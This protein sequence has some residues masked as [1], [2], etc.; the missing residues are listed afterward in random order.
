MNTVWYYSVTIPIPTYFPVLIK[1]VSI[2]RVCMRHQHRDCCYVDK[3]RIQNLQQKCSPTLNF[4][5][6]YFYVH[7]RFCACNSHAS[8]EFD[9]WQILILWLYSKILIFH[10]SFYHLDRRISPSHVT[11]NSAHI[12]ILW[13]W[14]LN[15]DQ[16][17]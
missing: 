10:R 2:L 8:K 4:Y 13:K 9:I 16:L 17:N 14:V 3:W 1:T 11:D 12:V 7:W 15:L 5:K 6:L